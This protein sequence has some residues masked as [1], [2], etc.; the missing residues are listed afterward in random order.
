MPKVDR[1]DV[2]S[3]CVRACTATAFGF[4]EFSNPESTL[5]ALRLLD[6]YRLG[7]KDLVVS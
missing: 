1:T 6:G 7:D 2:T 5:R 3:V 4:C